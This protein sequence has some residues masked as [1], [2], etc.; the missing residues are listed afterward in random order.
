MRKNNF[1]PNNII[2]FMEVRIQIFPYHKSMSFKEKKRF[3]NI[4]SISK[5]SLLLSRCKLHAVEYG[6]DKLILN[7]I[8]YN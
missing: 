5:S 7:I 4:N 8:Y 3:L 6:H 1:L 2:Y